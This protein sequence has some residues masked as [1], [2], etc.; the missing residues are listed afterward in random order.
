MSDVDISTRGRHWAYEMNRKLIRE[1][2]ALG[3]KHPQATIQAVAVAIGDGRLTIKQICKKHGVT[4]STVNGWLKKPVFGRKV[5]EARRDMQAAIMYLPLANKTV[6]A[7]K[8]QRDHDRIEKLESE[9]VKAA[10]DP[11]NPLFHVDGRP[12]VG[13]T[14]GLLA[15]RLKAKGEAEFV[16][17][18][19]LVETKAALRESVA[20]E[21]GDRDKNKE[22][23]GTIKVEVNYIDVR[24]PSVN[25]P[26]PVTV[27][28][29]PALEEPEDNG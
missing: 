15:K 28:V 19:D 22:Q 16:F 26:Q 10:R 6:R 5:A 13:A 27:D 20:V 9:L 24:P 1:Q 23:V 4:Q 29:P 8:A 25:E 21:V 17:N 2:K 14:T 7:E 3:D 11:N 12:V 18:R